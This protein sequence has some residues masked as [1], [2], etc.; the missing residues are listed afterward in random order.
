MVAEYDRNWELIAPQIATD[1]FKPSARQ[2]RLVYTKICDYWH[3]K[4]RRAYLEKSSRSLRRIYRRIRRPI[5]MK[6]SKKRDSS[7]QSTNDSDHEQQRLEVKTE[8]RPRLI[9][10]LTR[11][12]PISRTPTSS[13]NTPLLSNFIPSSSAYTVILDLE[14]MI[15]FS[16]SGHIHSSTRVLQPT[17]RRRNP[18]NAGRIQYVQGCASR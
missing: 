1:S 9:G 8:S 4:K 13:T 2:C 17:E 11:G 3:I 10:S 12:T 5:R 15:Q 7:Q 14:I 16:F 6:H 18:A